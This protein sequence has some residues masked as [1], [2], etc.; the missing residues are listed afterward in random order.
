MRARGRQHPTVYPLMTIQLYSMYNCDGDDQIVAEQTL[1]GVDAAPQCV[2]SLTVG[3][4]PSP[5][6]LVHC[7]PDGT[8]N[9]TDCGDLGCG[10]TSDSGPCW[11]R[12]SVAVDSACFL[13]PSN[14]LAVR[15]TCRRGHNSTSSNHVGSTADNSAANSEYGRGGV[16][17]STPAYNRTTTRP[18]TT[19]TG[20]TNTPTAISAEQ[21]TDGGSPGPVVPATTVPA[22]IRYYYNDSHCSGKPSNGAA[23][24]YI[25]IDTCSQYPE[26]GY[27]PMAPA[28]TQTVFAT[29]G[30]WHCSDNGTITLNTCT[31][32]TC[33]P[34]SCTS[35][36]T[37][38]RGCIYGLPGDQGN[39]GRYTCGTYTPTT[40]PPTDSGQQVSAAH[41]APSPV[42]ASMVAACIVAACVALL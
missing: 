5:Y 14:L 8:V 26:F 32:P 4:D 19:T 6:M 38:S 28:A 1:T 40:N 41:S 3:D 17:S 42:I 13:W 20:P 27:Y 25:P 22:V 21:A 36:F 31:S 16:D 33:E 35:S 18:S 10:H 2:F 9:M 34:S 23:P 39:S 12:S 37:V 7:N 15:L 30:I 11:N 29:Y 24:D